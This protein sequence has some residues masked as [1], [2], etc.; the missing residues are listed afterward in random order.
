MV[1]NVASQF[2]PSGD[3]SLARCSIEPR[4]VVPGEDSGEPPGVPATD[5]G[6]AW[7]WTRWRV[8]PAVRKG[9]R[10]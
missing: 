9:S 3:W 2:M 7:R 8:L 10:S 5:P 1:A 6:S 4:G